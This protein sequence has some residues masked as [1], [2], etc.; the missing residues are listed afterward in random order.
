M[1]ASSLGFQFEQRH[2]RLS[3]EEMDL[4]HF[5]DCA[6]PVIATFG[7]SQAATLLPHLQPIFPDLVPSPRHT[8]SQGDVRFLDKMGGETAAKLPRDFVM[9][10]HQKNA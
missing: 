6:G 8:K 7:G 3:A 4:T 1:S 2:G 9:G 5:A 10:C